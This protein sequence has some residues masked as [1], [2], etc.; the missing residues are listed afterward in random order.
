MGEVEILHR[1]FTNAAE[2]GL[3][4]EPGATAVTLDERDLLQADLPVIRRAVD[5]LLATTAPAGHQDGYAVVRYTGDGDETYACLVVSYPD[6]F[7][8]ATGRSGFLNH[9]RLVRVSEPSLDVAA[10]FQA[11]G[12]FPYREVCE[13]AAPERRSAYLGKV[14]MEE[15]AIVVRPVA[16]A[17]LQDVPRELLTEFL[18]GCLVHLGQ[19][20]GETVLLPDVDPAKL[21]RAWAAL[22]LALQRRSSWA[23]GV[24]S[25]PV[26]VVFA[27]S[28]GK[29][30]SKDANR[31]LVETVQEYVS[32]LH[33]E[34]G[35]VDAILN[36]PAV[37][38]PAAFRDAVLNTAPA[39]PP[40]TPIP[41]AGQQDMA[42]KP[43]NPKVSPEQQWDPVPPDDVAGL[44][45]Q[46]KAMEASL[47][48]TIDERFAALEL[49]QGSQPKADRPREAKGVPPA[50]P[51][52]MATPKGERENAEPWWKWPWLPFVGV[53][54]I[55]LVVVA[56]VMWPKKQQEAPPDPQTETIEN[57]PAPV[58][59]PEEETPTPARRAVKAAEQSAD[60]GAWAEALKQFIETE[61]DLTAR[62]IDELSANTPSNVRELLNRFAARIGRREDLGSEG[63]L[64]RAGLRDLLVDCIAYESYLP[65]VKIDGKFADVAPNIETLKQRYGVKNKAKDPASR[66][67]QSEIILRWIASRE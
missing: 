46:Y 57:V 30:A 4:Q 29:A 12:D 22:P 2:G 23:V 58:F 26:D 7:E 13:A 56:V 25:C 1:I 9:A 59:T 48:K 8:D 17:E 44:N 32:L 20:K 63:P 5:D 62:A 11:A 66:E 27:R 15:P 34:P 55:A 51:A 45:R 47:R 64:S 54:V 28:H 49:R 40:T 50:A 38:T 14:G 43:R 65:D 60:A 53:I 18:V 37:T 39:T 6:L 35:T 61:P 19:N 31:T 67:L 52:A 42:R 21:V 41:I 36:D 10:L 24:A 16:A 3:F 33:S